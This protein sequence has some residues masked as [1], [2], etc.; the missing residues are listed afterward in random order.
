[1][2]GHLVGTTGHAQ[3]TPHRFDADRGGEEWGAELREIETVGKMPR[4]WN[5]YDGGLRVRLE[6]TMRDG[7]SELFVVP[8]VDRVIA[9]RAARRGRARASVL[10]GRP[11]PAPPRRH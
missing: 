11:A 3:F 9:S 4:T 7:H 1:V 6:L 10:R 2:G 5:R 8:K